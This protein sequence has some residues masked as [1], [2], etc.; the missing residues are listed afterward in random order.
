MER[1]NKNL[2]K[3]NKEKV[4]NRAYIILEISLANTRIN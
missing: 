1:W 2:K 3:E 4:W